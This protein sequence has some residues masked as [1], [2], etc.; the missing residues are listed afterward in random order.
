MLNA[1][2][3]PVAPFVKQNKDNLVITL[4]LAGDNQPE[5]VTLRA[6]VDNEET[7]LKMHK[8]RSQPQPGVTAWRANI[9]LLSGQPRR[10]YGFKL[11]WNNRQLWFTPQGFSRFPPARLEQFAVDHPDNGPQWVNDQVFYQI[12]PDRFARSEKRNADQ[13]KVYYHHAV[14]HDIILKKW[15]EP[16]TAQ[17]GGSTFYGGDLDG[18]SE[19]LPYLK[20]LGVTALYLNP[21]FKAP[22]YAPDP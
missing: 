10:R 11:L 1:W 2:H 6:E 4:W 17:A 16:L 22:G 18:I 9:D 19:K 15:D 3:L 14:G 20:K 12:F 8:V 13:D 5:R 21:V 7:S